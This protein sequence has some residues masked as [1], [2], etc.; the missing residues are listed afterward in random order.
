MLRGKSILEFGF[1][2]YG[3]SGSPEQFLLHIE[4][5]FA[6]HSVYLSAPDI[7]SFAMLDG[8]LARENA[9]RFVGALGEASQELL[10]LIHLYRKVSHALVPNVLLLEKTIRLY[11][12]RL[13]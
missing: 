1:L 6:K 4:L 7:G 13:D 3:K 11:S 8:S 5:L 10:I 9:Q 2:E 12:P